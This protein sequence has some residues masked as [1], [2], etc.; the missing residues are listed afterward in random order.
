MAFRLWQTGL[1]IQQDQVVII[2]LE[3][4][5]ARWSLRRWWQIPLVSGIVQQGQIVQLEALVDALR[6]W[7]R[8]L[9]IQHC[10]RMALPAARTLQK[11]LPRPALVLR[12]R[13]QAEWI[14]QSMAQSLDMEPEALC[15]DYLEREQENL[16]RVTAARQQDVGS[17]SRLAKMLRL[18]LTAITP[19]ACA[20]Q[21]FLPWLSAEAQCLA[22]CH[23]N[24]W[25]WAT[26]HNWGSCNLHEAP[27]P[28]H[29]AKHLACEAE[30]LVQC[31][32]QATMTPHLDP[33]SA[34]SFQQPPLPTCGDRFAIALALALGER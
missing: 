25:L 13:E 2:A 14:T 30:Q 6:D 3:H 24:R 10:I 19:D 12:E 16:Y 23:D 28:V 17:L 11:A 33:W 18:N 34:I 15:F 9:P 31:T 5:R 32:S 26:R 21:R 1:H 27:S 29:L 20:L 7:R 4:T 22:W 8:E